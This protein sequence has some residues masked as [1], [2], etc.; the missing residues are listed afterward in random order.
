M[1][2]RTQRF[3]QQIFVENAAEMADKLPKSV[4]VREWI[5][6]RQS[7]LVLTTRDEKLHP[8]SKKF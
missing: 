2:A 7:E 4:L 1:R 6:V 5:A 3:E 8:K